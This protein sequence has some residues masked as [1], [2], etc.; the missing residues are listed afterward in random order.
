MSTE[1]IQKSN[2]VV[3]LANETGFFLLCVTIEAIGLIIATC[4]L[5]ATRKALEF[6]QHSDFPPQVSHVPEYFTCGLFIILLAISSYLHIVHW[7]IM[8][9]LH[10]QSVRSDGNSLSPEELPS[11]Q[12]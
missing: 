5:E 2:I 6:V 1:Q 7:F 12:A 10:H 3:S 8:V 11:L 9:K 4:V